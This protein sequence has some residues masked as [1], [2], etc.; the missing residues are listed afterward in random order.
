M[1]YPHLNDDTF[2]YIDLTGCD[3]NF[4][5][6]AVVIDDDSSH[7]E[8]DLHPELIGTCSYCGNPLS[9]VDRKN[10]TV[11]DCSVDDCKELFCALCSMAGGCFS[12]PLSDLC[13]THSRQDDEARGR[14]VGAMQAFFTRIKREV[15]PDVK[16]LCDTVG[17]LCSC[18]NCSKQIF[19]GMGIYFDIYAKCMGESPRVG[20]KRQRDSLDQI[21]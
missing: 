13:Q 11:S 12:S 21:D 3:D 20:R 2:T 18:A 19:T 9:N 14:A 17:R 4:L 6:D 5:E 15:D 10:G 7:G 16:L 1:A 8:S